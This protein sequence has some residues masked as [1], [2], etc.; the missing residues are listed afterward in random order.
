MGT[1]RQSDLNE[2]MEPYNHCNLPITDTLIK[3]NQLSGRTNISAPPV[4]AHCFAR[5]GDTRHM[6]AYI[7]AFS[8]SNK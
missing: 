7:I 6:C 2:Y 4:S 1:H 8:E 3:S 5:M